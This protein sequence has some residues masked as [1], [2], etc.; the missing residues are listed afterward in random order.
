M[1]RFETGRFGPA[2]TPL[3]QL[4][5]YLE[6][7]C[8]ESYAENRADGS[9][10]TRLLFRLSR[11]FDDE[12]VR[13]DATRHTTAGWETSYSTGKSPESREQQSAQPHRNTIG[14][15]KSRGPCPLCQQ[16]FTAATGGRS[17]IRHVAENN[18]VC[19]LWFVAISVSIKNALG[20]CL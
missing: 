9:V 5:Q 7:Y 18:R 10:L 2:Q 19:R 1:N 13:G 16:R 3:Q 17:T 15:D 8:T 6:K 20:A 11:N 14:A 4:T 12:D